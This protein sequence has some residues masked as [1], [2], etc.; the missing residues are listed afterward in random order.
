MSRNR[1]RSENVTLRSDITALCDGGLRVSA[2]SWLCVSVVCQAPRGP[3]KLCDCR[4]ALHYCCD[5]D[6][7]Q[8]CLCISVVPQ[9]LR[10]C[11]RRGVL[12]ACD[13]LEVLADVVCASLL[14]LR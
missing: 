6:A 4:V 7:L 8:S 11:H 5:G 9:V 2:L 12:W 3:R 13:A 14:R 1:S 10:G